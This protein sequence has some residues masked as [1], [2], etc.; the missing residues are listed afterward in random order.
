MADVRDNVADDAAKTSAAPAAEVPSA[1][2]ELISE[3]LSWAKTIVFA[4]ALAL[5]VNNF[6]IVNTS[7]LSGSMENTI[8]TDDRVVAFRLSYLFSEPERYDIVVFRYPE[9]ESK[10]YV[11]RIVGLPGETIEVREGKIYIDGAETPL[12]DEFIL[13]DPDIPHRDFAAY[14]IPAG[15]YFMMG[16][17]R[18]WSD[19]S[20]RW[21]YQ[22]EGTGEWENKTVEKGKILGKAIF[23]YWP[24]LKNLLG[25]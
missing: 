24:S 3:A 1:K 12:R 23:R 15:E 11:K 14:T 18:D 22:I 5:L 16:D 13:D 20:R 17:N 25:A 9:D 4:V 8:M 7:V 21:G 19:D 10:L 6:I 2:N